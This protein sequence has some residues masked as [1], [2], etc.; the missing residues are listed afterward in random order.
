MTEKEAPATGPSLPRAA[1][2]EPQ[3]NLTPRSGPTASTSVLTV[4]A[5]PVPIQPPVALSPI[6]SP[7]T[8]G[9]GIGGPVPDTLQALQPP[10]DSLMAPA[11][12]FLKPARALGPAEQAFSPV[13]DP[14]AGAF[15][16]PAPASLFPVAGTAASSAAEVPSHGELPLYANSSS[17]QPQAQLR[18]PSQSNPQGLAPAGQ[19]S[20]ETGKCPQ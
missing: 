12:V 18:S 6:V 10:G 20:S 11:P 2:A 14:E 17:A 9:K 16:A 3:L 8:P 7:K 4:P 19:G 13:E 15:P 1:S 5:L